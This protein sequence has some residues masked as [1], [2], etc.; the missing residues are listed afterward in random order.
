MIKNILTG[1][2]AI[3]A[4]KD[5]QKEIAIIKNPE[6]IHSNIN[7]LIISKKAGI[8]I[9]NID[10]II[11][12]P[13]NVFYDL[14]DFKNYIVEKTIRTLSEKYETRE[15]R[16]LDEKLDAYLA[17]NY[18]ESLAVKKLCY[19]YSNFI[20]KNV[21]LAK[22]IE[23]IIGFLTLEQ[24]QDVVEKIKIDFYDHV[25]SKLSQNEM[26]LNF[27]SKKN[28]NP[29]AIQTLT[30]A[31]I[32]EFNEDLFSK[33]FSFFDQA[34]VLVYTYFKKIIIEILK[35]KNDKK[36]IS[37]GEYETIKNKIIPCEGLLEFMLLIKGKL[38]LDYDFFPNRISNYLEKN[39]SF[40]YEKMNASETRN[41][42]ANL[43]SR[44]ANHQPK[45]YLISEN[46][47]SDE[48]LLL[49]IAIQNELNKISSV[50]LPDSFA[51]EIKNS[52]SNIKLFDNIYTIK[53]LP[54]YTTDSFIELRKIA[55]RRAVENKCSIEN[56][57]A[58]DSSEN[59]ILGF[60]SAEVL[61]TVY[62]I[63]KYKKEIYND[64]ANANLRGGLPE[65]ILKTKFFIDY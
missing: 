56:I 59:G 27:I 26:I 21:L 11:A 6:V 50:D 28:F 49:N 25:F 17:A 36:Y 54:S 42:L 31:A 4:L 33:N 61:Y 46:N 65:F 3:K 16:G 19:K 24:L 44:F 60:R 23:A 29:Q 32:K 43:N 9:E 35:N 39:H 58:I 18:E 15:W 7:Y 13:D 53:I 20:K 34:V 8:P 30:A 63:S 12:N 37:S 2:E 45:L 48:E 14:T 22:A 1:E 38:P 52:V 47:R 62:I 51:N 5:L 64:C 57:I 40:D 41:I 10:C 55:T